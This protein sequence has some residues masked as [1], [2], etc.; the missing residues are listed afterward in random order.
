[1]IRVGPSGWA[2]QGL[3][4]IQPIP[5]GT[6]ILPYQGERIEK[7]ESARR[8][9]AGNNYIFRLNYAWDIDGSDLENLARYINHSCDPNCRAEIRGE[10]IWI[11]SEREIP[12]GQELSFNYGFDLTDYQRFPCDCG[13][14]VCCG[15]MLAREFWGQIPQE[16]GEGTFSPWGEGTGCEQ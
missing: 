3:F 14:R 7:A 15:Y 1:M 13:A 6:S 11:V 12:A 8:K 16:R 5:A 4:A 9:A 2:G 10:A